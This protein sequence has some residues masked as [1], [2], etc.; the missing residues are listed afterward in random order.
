M[1]TTAARPDWSLSLGWKNKN[2]RETVSHFPWADDLWAF[3]DRLMTTL[4]LM[5]LKI[6]GGAARNQGDTVSYGRE[7]QVQAPAKITRGRF[8]GCNW[9]LT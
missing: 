5:P 8:A 2:K 4:T 3:D 9:C 7:Q 1:A 6:S